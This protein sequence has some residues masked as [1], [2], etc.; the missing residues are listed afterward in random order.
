MIRRPPRSTRTD[1]LF[2]YTTRFRSVVDMHPAEHLARRVDAPR[3]AV[4]HPVQRR[5]A[6]TVDA[7]QAEHAHIL[8]QRLPRQIGRDP[9]RPPAT[10]DGSGPVEIGTAGVAI[11]ENGRASWRDRAGQYGW[12]W[13]EGG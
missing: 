13:V 12:R 4:Q 7:G 3:P 2:P 9:R 8:A 1:T 6:G 5:P 10:A 11:E